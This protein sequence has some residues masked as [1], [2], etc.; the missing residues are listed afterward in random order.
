M[1]GV[2]LSV[3]GPRNRVNGQLSSLAAR[4]GGLRMRRI[5]STVAA[6][7]LLALPVSATSATG[8]AGYRFVGHPYVAFTDGGAL[9]VLLRLNRSL[10]AATATTATCTAASN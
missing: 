3:T 4:I 10:P 8:S 2:F 1:G 7:A 5:V 6:L 9:S